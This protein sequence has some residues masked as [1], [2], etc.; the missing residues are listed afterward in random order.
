MNRITEKHN[1]IYHVREITSWSFQ[2]VCPE[3][4]KHKS[5][6][7]IRYW[8]QFSISPVISKFIH[9]DKSVQSIMEAYIS[10]GGY[11]NVD[12]DHAG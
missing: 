6:L 9:S 12:I 10:G 3:A 8:S 4:Q 2:D 11:C 5:Y 1:S 7:I